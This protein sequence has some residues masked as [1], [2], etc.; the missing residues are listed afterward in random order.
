MNIQSRDQSHY[1]SQLLEPIA[2]ERIPH[3]IYEWA[4]IANDFF[5]SLFFLVGSVLFFYPAQEDLGTWLFVAGSAQMMLGPVI[6]IANKLQVR[7]IRKS[8]LHW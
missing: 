1:R 5:I 6:R 8:V 2:Q 4:H 3:E 7:H